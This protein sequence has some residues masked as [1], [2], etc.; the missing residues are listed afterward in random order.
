VWFIEVPGVSA[1]DI[2]IDLED[3]HLLRIK[4]KRKHRL[5][6]GSI[7]E[8]EFDVAFRLNDGVDPSQLKAILSAGILQVQ[9]PN[10]E[11]E[12]RRISIV[13]DVEGEAVTLNE[14][15]RKDDGETTAS[16][17]NILVEAGDIGTSGNNE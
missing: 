9:V 13:T 8:T 7:E 3:Q 5:G 4:G 6:S 12:T 1:K 2:E 15:Y 17:E 10:K 11:K 14:L 16:S